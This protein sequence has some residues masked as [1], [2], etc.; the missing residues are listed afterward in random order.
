M[1]RRWLDVAALAVRLPPVDCGARGGWPRG[2]TR[3]GL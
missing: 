3:N 2:R 1:S